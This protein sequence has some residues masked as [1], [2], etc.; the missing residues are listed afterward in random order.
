MSKAVCSKM[1][2]TIKSLF[3]ASAFPF[4][5]I[6]VSNLE[7]ED[8][9]TCLDVCSTWNNDLDTSEYWKLAIGALRNRDCGKKA[10]K[11]SK[12]TVKIF[13]YFSES[14]LWNLTK[15]D[16]GNLEDDK[17]EFYCGASDLMNAIRLGYFGFFQ[18]VLDNIPM[19]DLVHK[20][21]RRFKY[22]CSGFYDPPDENPWK[23]AAV[24]G[25]PK[26]LEL[27]LD[28]L[29]GEQVLEF[30]EDDM[31]LDLIEEGAD[32]NYENGQAQ[33]L[34]VLFQK[35][36]ITHEAV[37]WAAKYGDLEIFKIIVDK[38]P[39]EVLAK[40]EVHNPLSA[41]IPWAD[42][43]AKPLH[44]AAF[45]GHVEVIEFLASKLSRQTL[46]ITSEEDGSALDCAAKNGHYKVVQVLLKHLP[47]K[48]KSKI[49]NYLRSAMECAEKEGHSEIAKLLA[50][51]M[52][53]IT[54]PTSKKLP[55]PKRSR[56]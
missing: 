18:L 25:Y 4:G 47:T 2:S 53:S 14:D 30:Y 52:E 12:A 48:G 8:F 29:P 10:A 3:N 43:P 40:D 42:L 24:C 51:K 26:I 54:T 19:T 56:H 15:K 46:M 20:V 34:R 16:A 28:S 1:D 31:T 45:E 44:V 5:K 17:D 21:D 9:L 6:V 33:A 23:L 35:M 39:L 38:M 32:G 22:T 55:N 7:F 49:S 37:F 41:F 27:I 50:T 11:N 13:Q 36:F